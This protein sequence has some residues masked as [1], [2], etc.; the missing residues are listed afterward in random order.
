M[1]ALNLIT[2]LATCIRIAKHVWKQEISLIP[3][4]SLKALVKRTTWLP[5]CSKSLSMIFRYIWKDAVSLHTQSVNCL[6][7][8]ITLSFFHQQLWVYR[9]DLLNLRSIVLIGVLKPTFLIF[10]KA[11]RNSQQKILFRNNVI[12]CVSNYKNFG[13]LFTTSESFQVAKLDIESLL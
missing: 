6:I 11:G 3:F 4:Q 1:W 7:M 8:Q 10:N 2:S 13:V 12:D 5:H 9:Q